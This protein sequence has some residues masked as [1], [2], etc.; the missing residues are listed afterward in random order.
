MIV[1]KFLSGFIYNLVSMLIS[2]IP[3]SISMGSV[4][5]KHNKFF[6]QMDELILLEELEKDHND[7]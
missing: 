3:M 7:L 1:L 5:V 6:W 4:C 2:L